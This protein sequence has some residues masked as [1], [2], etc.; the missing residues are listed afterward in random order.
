MT[1]E[2]GAAELSI[3]MEALISLID[4]GDERQSIGWL[5]MH[6]AALREGLHDRAARAER[7]MAAAAL[8][9]KA[10]GSISRAADSTLQILQYDG[11]SVV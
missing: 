3:E 11:P 2:A 10:F 5:V 4:T 6:A 8:E 7:R 1:P 9:D